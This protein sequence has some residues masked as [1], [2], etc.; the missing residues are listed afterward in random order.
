LVAELEGVG[1]IDFIY[2]FPYLDVFTVKLTVYDGFGNQDSEI[3]TYIIDEYPCTDDC[4]GGP[5][6]PQIVE[7]RSKPKGEITLIDL[8]AVDVEK[9]QTVITA[10]KVYEADS[11]GKQIRI[12]TKIIEE[13]I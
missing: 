1:P 7:N 8:T 2:A 13:K 5:S 11:D 6:I 12:R 4:G 3:K 9:C 10:K